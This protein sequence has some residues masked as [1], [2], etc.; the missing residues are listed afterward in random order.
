MPRHIDAHA[1][2]HTRYRRPHTYTRTHTQLTHVQEMVVA[3]AKGER[4][5]MSVVRWQTTL[6]QQTEQ[7]ARSRKM[8]TFVTFGSFEHE[9]EHSITRARTREPA[10]ARERAPA[11]EHEHSSTSTRAR[12][13][14]RART[15]GALEHEHEVHSSTSTS[16]RWPCNLCEPS[17]ERL[18][19]LPD[20]FVIMW[21]CI[22][23]D[24]SRC[25]EGLPVVTCQFSRLRTPRARTTD[26]G[27]GPH[28]RRG[29]RVGSLRA[30]EPRAREKTRGRKRKKC[31]CA[32]KAHSNIVI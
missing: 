29:V 19:S 24:G 31:P 1:H 12:A 15:R 16:T 9:H 3:A 14:A 4:H 26:L 11:L 8:K 20:N 2:A 28:L 10:R 30:P 22:R 5:N 6:Q 7:K 13:P 25:S 27:H 18:L 21:V 32:R 23:L 17:G